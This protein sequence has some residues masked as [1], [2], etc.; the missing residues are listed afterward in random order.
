MQSAD[1]PNPAK[2]LAQRGTECISAP[3]SWSKM[4]LQTQAS[5]RLKQCQTGKVNHVVKQ[6]VYSTTAQVALLGMLHSLV[7]AAD[8]E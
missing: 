7:T 4:P 8:T 5:F 1:C 3:V 6:C 2:G